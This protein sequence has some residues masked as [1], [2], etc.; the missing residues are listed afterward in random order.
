MDKIRIGIVGYGNLG[1]G[2]EC[3]V[4]QNP[5]MEIA[6]I[7]T[8]RDPSVI[9][10]LTEGVKECPQYIQISVRHASLFPSHSQMTEAGFPLSYVCVS[11]I[12]TVTVSSF[13]APSTALIT[14][15]PVVLMSYLSW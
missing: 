4:R 10:P 6:G 12:Y 7:F 3:A 14:Q 15:L 2:V 9:R 1:R 5:D 8:R 11:L 13:P